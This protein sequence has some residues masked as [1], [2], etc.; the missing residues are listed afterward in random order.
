MSNGLLKLAAWI[1]LFI[2]S[3]AVVWYQM[4]PK[5]PR[6]ELPTKP[7]ELRSED[8]LEQSSLGGVVRENV[9]QGLTSPPLLVVD[10]SGEAAVP[11]KADEIPTLTGQNIVPSPIL[12]EIPKIKD[13]A[14]L[15][16]AAPMITLPGGSFRMG[17]DTAVEKDQ[18]PSHNVRL[19]PFKIDQYEVTNRQFQ[20]F[21][22]ET[23]YQTTAERFGWSYVFDFERKTWVRMVGACWWNPTGKNPHGNSES[24]AVTAILDH[25]VVHVSWEDAQAFCRWSG[26]HL[27]SEAEWEF[28][29]KGGLL[30]AMYPWGDRRQIEGK[31]QANFWQGWYPNE[32]TAADGF[33]LL[34]PVGS[35]PANR[36]GLFDVGGN[37]WEWCSDRYAADYYRR[38]LMD[39]PQ[40]PAQEEGKTAAVARLQLRKENGRY[41]GERLEGT[42]EVPLRVIRGGS[43]LS[44]ENGDAGYRLT[45]RGSQ[46]QTLSFQDIGFRCA[47]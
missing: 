30:D 31:Y 10:P 38:S 9:I 47:E 17:N 45:A 33:L 43:F 36:Y 27:P 40:G 14:K 44:A 16:A 22:R 20:L 4:T 15:D 12:N 1:L 8:E 25:P 18:R 6:T 3:V 7:I 24:G 5:L 32:N 42:E 35:F 39:N 19:A 29:A 26:K 46:P 28:A 11:L 41:V 13:R 34:S 21:V 23:K 2:A 37:A